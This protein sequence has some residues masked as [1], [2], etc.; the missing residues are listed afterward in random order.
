MLQPWLQLMQATRNHRKDMKRTELVLSTIEEDEGEIFDGYGGPTSCCSV[1][2]I[3]SV[4]SAFNS[5]KRTTSV[6]TVFF[7][8][9]E[10]I[11]SILGINSI[12]HQSSSVMDFGCSILSTRHPPWTRTRISTS[13]QWC[14]AWPRPRTAQGNHKG[15]YSLLLSVRGN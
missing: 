10:G 5:K 12:F 3:H 11:D 14:P 13:T 1:E 15:V 2:L 9:F 7:F 6:S 8:R 4:I